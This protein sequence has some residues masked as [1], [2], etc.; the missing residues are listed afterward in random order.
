[1]DKHADYPLDVGRR[2]LPRLGKNTIHLLLELRVG[3]AFL[4]ASGDGSREIS[5][6]LQAEVV[7]TLEIERRRLERIL[8]VLAPACGR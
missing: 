7:E 2:V 5:F 6:R 3:G 1:L 4:G 8:G